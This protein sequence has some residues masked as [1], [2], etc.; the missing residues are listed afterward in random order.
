MMLLGYGHEEY[1]SGRVEPSPGLSMACLRS[2]FV[3]AYEHILSQV[4][5]AC[6]SVAVP[7]KG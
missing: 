6:N 3:K 2:R 1:T 4:M 7:I 5:I